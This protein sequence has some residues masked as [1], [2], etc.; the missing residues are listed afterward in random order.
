MGRGRAAALLSGRG[1]KKR[2][3]DQAAYNSREEVKESERDAL[4]TQVRDLQS[5]L[6]E[7]HSYI[8]ANNPETQA[9]SLI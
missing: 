8:Q 9:S 1:Y 6:A 7:A 4:L 2:K 3:L 5:Q